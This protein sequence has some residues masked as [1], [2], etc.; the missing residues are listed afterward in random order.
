MILVM[1]AMGRPFKPLGCCKV[2][3]VAVIFPPNIS[4]AGKD[5]I[6]NKMADFSVEKEK[7]P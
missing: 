7:P 6:D 5:K 4:G 2:S 1:V 3:I